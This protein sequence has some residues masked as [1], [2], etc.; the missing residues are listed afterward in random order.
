MNQ[1]WENI[2]RRAI[3]A[4]SEPLI[5]ISSRIRS[6][7]DGRA[8]GGP[9]YP[10]SL[11]RQKPRGFRIRGFVFHLLCPEALSDEDFEAVMLELV[12]GAGFEP[13]AFRL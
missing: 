2:V 13:A 9:S 4:T 1:L 12:A 8:A 5:A 11:K 7:N 3:P 10:R 6:L